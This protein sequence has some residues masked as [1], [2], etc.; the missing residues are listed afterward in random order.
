MILSGAVAATVL[1][2]KL[3]HVISVGAIGLGL[4]V[5]ATA[6]TNTP[7]QVM[8]TLFLVGCFVT[9]LQA[10][11][12]TLLQTTV[13]SDVLGRVGAALNTTIGAANLL[14][15]ACA[16]LLGALLGVRNVFVFAGIVSVAAGLLA[17]RLFRQG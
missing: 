10:A 17:L 9:P 2:F 1:R 12:S 5:A 13:A 3:G 7:W 16:G 14:S 15:M 8:V 4:A 11:V 6:F